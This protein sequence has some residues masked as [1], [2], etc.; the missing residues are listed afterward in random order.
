MEWTLA[1]KIGQLV[2]CSLD[3]REIDAETEAF[4]RRYHVGNI[5]HFGNNVYGFEDARALNKRLEALIRESCA[6]VS[7]LIA[8]DHEGGRVQRFSQGMTWF[9]PQMALAAADDESLTREVGEAMG[10]ELR[11]AGFNL[12]F[13]PVVDVN[14]NPQNPVIGARSFGDR[15]E[16]VV[17]HA[18]ALA[19]GLRS[20]GVAACLKHFP[21]HGDT[22]LDSH[23]ALPKVEKG[24]EALEREE[25]APYRALCGQVPCVMTTHILFPALEKE[26]VPATMS[27][28]ILRGVLREDIGFDGVIVTDGMHMRAIADHYGVQR[29][30]VE[31]VKAGCD[32]LCVGTGG[33]GARNS[34]A[35]CMEALLQAAQSGELP[36]ERIDEA[37]G[38]VLRLKAW[39]AE[40]AAAREPD[41]EKHA[42]LNAQVCERAVTALTPLDAPISGRIVCTSAPVR[43]LAYGLTHADPRSQSFA[44]IAGALLNAPRAALDGLPDDCDTLLIGANALTPDCPALKQANEA[45]ER[46]MRVGLVLTG[47]PYGAPLVPKGCAAVCVYGLTPQTVAAALDVLMGRKK[48]VGHLP[49]TVL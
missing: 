26:N 23:Y 47:L 21:G 13:S 1:Q 37:V 17:R 4:L 5:I 7:P 28:A 19:A 18:R 48:A 35:K 39:L 24:R 20:A 30:C 16:D 11:A 46:G 6:G 45:L 31:A 10:A 8:V 2:M 9:P 27:P 34:Q 15:A 25:L 40:Q 43:E 44:E 3:G 32:L 42:K 33:A 41:F 12:S 22:A 49:V 36:M 38:R 14:S 29:G